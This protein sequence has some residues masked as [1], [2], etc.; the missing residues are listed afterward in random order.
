ME[1]TTYIIENLCDGNSFEMELTY[2]QYTAILDLKDN[3]GYVMEDVCI[4]EK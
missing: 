3:L 1:T 2:E 4:E